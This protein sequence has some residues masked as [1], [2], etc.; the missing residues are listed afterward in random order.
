MRDHP[1]ALVAA[2][3]YPPTVCITRDGRSG[4]RID[5]AHHP[6][7]ARQHAIRRYLREVVEPI[8]AHLRIGDLLGWL[9]PYLVMRLLAI[10]HLGH[11]SPRDT[12]LALGLLADVLHPDTTL[13]DFLALTTSRS[14]T[15]R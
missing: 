15:A 1:C 13:H 2:A 7:P 12:A 6:S 5:H 11:L 10:Y 9:R 3:L 4:L 8:A 14:Q